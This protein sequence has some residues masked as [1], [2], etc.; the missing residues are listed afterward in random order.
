MNNLLDKLTVKSSM[1]KILK[2]YFSVLDL[3]TKETDLYNKV[4][5]E[6]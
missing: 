2:R 1:E 3:S 5:I 6:V 4:V